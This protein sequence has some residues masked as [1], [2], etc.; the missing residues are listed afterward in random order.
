[1]L[2]IAMPVAVVEL[3]DGRTESFERL[4]LTCGAHPFVPP[5]PGVV[6]I[7]GDIG[8]LNQYFSVL[9]MVA[10]VAPTA[11]LTND[12]PK[13]EGSV[14]TVSFVDVV[15]P[16]TGDSFTYSFDWDN[17]GTYDVASQ[18]EASASHAWPDNGTYT[19]KGLVEDPALLLLET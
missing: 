8:F 13:A 11:A 15:D 19:V 16:G 2:V 5:I 10:N 7:P 17:N 1:M 6:V 18:T 12:G 9:L 14:V 4:I 3:G